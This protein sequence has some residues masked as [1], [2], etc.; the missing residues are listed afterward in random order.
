MDFS[1]PQGMTAFTAAVYRPVWTCDDDLCCNT[2]HF[3]S[4]LSILHV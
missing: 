3:M 4:C 1:V 2:V